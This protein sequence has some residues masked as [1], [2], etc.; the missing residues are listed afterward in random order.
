MLHNFAHIHTLVAETT[1]HHQ[2]PSPFIRP[3]TPMEE[4]PR[5]ESSVSYS[6]TLRHIGS[7]CRELNY[8]PS[9]WW[10]T[11]LS[12]PQPPH[13]M[14]FNTLVN[15]VNNYLLVMNEKV[16]AWLLKPMLC[17]IAGLYYIHAVHYIRTLNAVTCDPHC[18]ISCK[19]LN[20][21]QLVLT[22]VAESHHLPMLTR[23]KQL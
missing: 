7:R 23:T 19:S 14:P 13:Q 5:A 4:P 3:H 2:E 22:W 8:R 12:E 1:M 6:R 10:T 9:N 17:C 11:L 21:F 16:N 18:R 20:I 15:I